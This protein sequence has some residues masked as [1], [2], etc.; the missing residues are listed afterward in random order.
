MGYTIELAFDAR[1]HSN[2][3][4]QITNLEKIAYEYGCERYYTMHEAEAY[5]KHISRNHCVTIITFP[6]ESKYFIEFI[7]RIKKE[8][9]NGIHIECVYRDEGLYMLLHAST[10]YLKTL[11]KNVALEFKQNHKSNPPK[12]NSFD[13]KV[14]NEFYKNK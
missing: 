2:V 8:R 1:K 3:T 10:R 4:E 7:Q 11:E 13:Y 5:H 6:E 12:K 9:K 14:F